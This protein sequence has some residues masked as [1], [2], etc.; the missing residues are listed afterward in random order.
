MARPAH[1]HA[2]PNVGS[3]DRGWICQL[4]SVGAIGGAVYAV[5]A[6]LLLAVVVARLVWGLPVG[7]L[8]RDPAVVAGTHPFVGWLSNVGIL[9][10][11]A[12]ASICLFTAGV[13]RNR[14]CQQGTGR[15]LFAAGLFT[16]LVLIDDFFMLH[17]EVFP[18]YLGVGEMPFYCFC[19]VALGALILVFRGQILS[20]DYG[21][22]FVA[23]L[24]FGVSI[25][26][27]VVSKQTWVTGLF[28][29]EDGIKL[30]GIVSWA[31]YFGK[32]SYAS[33]EEDRGQAA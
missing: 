1:T 23:V 11:C 16:L 17:D 19:G 13:P 20:A 33:L 3:A 27:D 14:E 31:L 10:W 24:C 30:L 8:T 9:G 25:I 2:R 6:L 12:A 7:D 28:F 5:T 29:F 21:V 22:F 18:G 4:K 26:F 32:L 15:F